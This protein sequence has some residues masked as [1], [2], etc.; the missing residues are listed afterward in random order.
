MATGRTVVVVGASLAGATAAAVLREEGFDGRL[1]LIGDETSAPYERPPLSKTYL[2]GEQPLEDLFVRPPELW[3][4]QG[5][6]ARL[7]ERAVA[8]DP[9]ERTVTLADGTSIA[10]D[11]ALVAT[12]VRNRHLAVPGRDLQGIFE[13]R[14]LAD[15]DRIREAAARSSTVVVVGFGFIGA[16][17]GASLRRLGLEVEVV[18]IFHTAMVRVLGDRIGRLFEAIHRDHGVR[19]RFEDRVERFEG[20]GRVERVVTAGGATLD[21]DMVVVGVGTE[22]NAEVMHGRGLAADGGIEV[23]PTLETAFGGVFAAGDV[24]TH[25]HPLFGPIRV[26]HFDNAL[27]TGEHAARNLLGAG[28]VFA[29]P[30]WFWSDQYDHELQ[31]AGVVPRVDDATVVIRGSLDERRFCAFLL[32]DEGVL[33]GS[34]SLDRP[35]DCRRSM[36]L[37]AAQVAPPPEALADPEIDLRELAPG[38]DG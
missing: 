24:A 9:D 2:R 12:G 1:V 36:P 27:K 34:I 21:C 4:A 38:R 13:L 10:F 11:R 8:L 18:E 16:E 17:V 29:D 22:P 25:E 33:R 26:E 6:E 35:R 20:A 14:T 5:I 32:D 28:G 7:G 15:A 37:I 30:H 3:A 23:G 19:F 31:M